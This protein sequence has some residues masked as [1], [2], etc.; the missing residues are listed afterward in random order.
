[1]RNAIYP[2]LFSAMLLAL[3]SVGCGKG[4]EDAYSQGVDAYAKGDFD[5]A[6]SF[7][8][9][10]IRLKPDYA[11]AYYRRGRATPG[12]ATTTKRLRTSPRRF[13][14]SPTTPRQMHTASVVIAYVSKGEYDKAIADYTEAIRLKPD[15]AEAYKRRG[16]AY[17]RGL[18]YVNNNDDNKAIADFTEAIK[19]KPRFRR[20]IRQAW[21]R[22]HERGRARQGDCGLH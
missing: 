2:L 17:G 20:G 3:S 8:T 12:K 1:M 9:E 11:D 18:A 21:S 13:A 22:L 4:A 14:S 6:A 15:C 7:F 10:A 19:L 5:S 16:F